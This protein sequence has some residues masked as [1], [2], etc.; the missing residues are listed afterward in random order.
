MTSYKYIRTCIQRERGGEGRGLEGAEGCVGVVECGV[1]PDQYGP[2]RTTVANPRHI[3][4]EKEQTRID[5]PTDGPRT[6]ENCDMW[7]TGDPR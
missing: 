7:V 4:Q 6:L 1:K 5:R 2:K 3:N